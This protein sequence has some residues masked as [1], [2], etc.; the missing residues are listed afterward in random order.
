LISKPTFKEFIELIPLGNTVLLA[1]AIT[2][3]ESKRAEDRAVAESL[4]ERLL[5]LTGKAIRIGIT[6][7]PGVGKST[8]IEAFGKYLTSQQK[9]V[10]ILAV[11]PS[12]AKTR[13]SILGDKTRMEELAKDPLAFIRPTSTGTA[14]G[15]VADRTR[16]AMLLCEAAGFDVVIIETVG[17]GQSET[18][19]RNMVDFFLLLML[20]GAGDELQGIKKGIMEMAD[21]II[22]NKADGDNIKK[23][24]EA[25]ADFQH[26][27]HL[28]SLPESGWSPRVLTA[29]A[30]EKRGIAETWQ[31]ISE[32]VASTQANGYF[33]T[34]RQQQ[35]IEWFRESMKQ[36]FIHQ[37]M[38]NNSVREQIKKMESKILNKEILPSAA[39]AEIIRASFS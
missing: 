11:D 21:G 18:V 2:L 4:I 27:L 3:A 12:S 13:G 1:Q 6:G 9:R 31:L 38:E 35:D 28:F 5:H 36:L 33:Q 20:A 8:F 23:S 37:L 15:G 34:Q 39:A 29:S 30:L 26:A 14:L 32:Y 19:V 25:R 24:N 22:I 7:V 10:A 17:V 16:E